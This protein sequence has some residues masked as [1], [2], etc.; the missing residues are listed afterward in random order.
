MLDRCNFLKC[1]PCWCSEEEQRKVNASK[2]RR[3]KG[4][5][6]IG[7]CCTLLEWLYTTNEQAQLITK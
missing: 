2:E 1:V 7:E 4:Q 5:C 6:A 3:T